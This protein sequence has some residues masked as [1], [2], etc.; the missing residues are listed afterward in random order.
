MTPQGD[1]TTLYTFCPKENCDTGDFP[2][3]RLYQSPEGTWY[4]TTEFG[5]GPYGAGTIFKINLQGKLSTLSSFQ[6]TFVNLAGGELPIGG[7][8]QAR[9]GEL[10]GTTFYGG[11]ND[12]ATNALF[13]TIFR[14]TTTGVLTT[15]YSFCSQPNC[16]DGVQ[17]WAALI[18]ADNGDLYGTTLRSG[19]N[20][21]HGTVSAPGWLLTSHLG[22]C[23]RET[24]VEEPWSI[25]RGQLPDRPDSSPRDPPSWHHPS[26]E[27]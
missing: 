23:L 15:L 14:I 20:G 18:Q 8:V 16:S 9:N 12:T 22:Q 17:P 5:G 3:G 7:L 2:I 11:A 27:M 6:N 26:I 10:Y 21:E 25:W 24:S 1:V 13:G 4:G 19:P